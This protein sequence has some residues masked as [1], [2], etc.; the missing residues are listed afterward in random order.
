MWKAFLAYHNIHEGT[1]AV[2]LEASAATKVMPSVPRPPPKIHPDTNMA[3]WTEKHW[4]S[5]STAMGRRPDVLANALFDA[6]DDVMSA[7]VLSKIDTLPPKG[8]PT[9]TDALSAFTSHHGSL[10][11]IFHILNHYRPGNITESR[12]KAKEQLE[13]LRDQLLPDGSNAQ[14]ILNS[15]LSLL[16]QCEDLFSVPG[17]I[18]ALVNTIR[19]C[20]KIVSEL[21]VRDTYTIPRALRASLPQ[22]CLLFFDLLACG[23]EC[24]RAGS[25][26]REA[27]D[28]LELARAHAAWRRT[29]CLLACKACFI[30][31]GSSNSGRKQ[32]T[33]SISA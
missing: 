16:H 12:N 10:Q 8:D 18:V 25:R 5:V 22:V 21:V 11:F 14:A 6:L 24:A 32:G 31:R 3:D 19:R 26:A 15:F 28:C 2:T 20:E 29:A 33:P 13:A 27:A 4:R 1:P 30:S 7:H 23:L 17:K 9:R